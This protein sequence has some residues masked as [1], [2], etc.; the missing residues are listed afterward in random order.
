MSEAFNF[1]RACF[2]QEGRLCAHAVGT[3]QKPKIILPRSCQV[4]LARINHRTRELRDSLAA[5]VAARSSV[6]FQVAGG[7]GPPQGPSRPVLFSLLLPSALFPAKRLPPSSS[8]ATSTHLQGLLPVLLSTCTLKS[9]TPRSG[10]S[11]LCKTL[12]IRGDLSILLQDA[13]WALECYCLQ[14]FF[15]YFV[16]GFFPIKKINVD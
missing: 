10:S 13:K 16:H 4:L 9:P 15:F 14:F 8:P 11:G 12:I 2:W 3:L 1:P 7:R 6:P 5:L